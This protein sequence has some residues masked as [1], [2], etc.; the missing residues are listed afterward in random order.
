MSARRKL[1]DEDTA[2]KD[3]CKRSPEEFLRFF[4]PNA[5]AKIDFSRPIRF[6]DKELNQASA[7]ARIP[8]KAADLLFEAAKAGSR[9]ELVYIHLEIQGRKEEYFAQRMGRYAMMIDQVVGVHPMSLILLID[10]DEHFFP[11]SYEVDHE[12]SSTRMDFYTQKLLYLARDYGNIDVSSPIPAWY[13]QLQL[14]VNG[15]KRRRLTDAQRYEAKKELLIRITSMGKDAE[16]ANALVNF[17]DWIMQL[18]ENEEARL[19]EQLSV[20][21]ESMGVMAIAE[22]TGMQKGKLEGTLTNSQDVLIRQIKKRRF[23]IT[24]EQEAEI[25]NVTD[26]STLD[27]AL[28]EVVTAENLEEIFSILGISL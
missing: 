15:Y 1:G 27:L 20:K 3:A 5:A 7:A 19:Y 26:Q 4:F 22:R 21:E 18:A 14:E 24:G 16:D 2:W 17:I 8:G 9:D 23:F 6:L 10:D 12:V 25:R 13:M 11:T 28:D